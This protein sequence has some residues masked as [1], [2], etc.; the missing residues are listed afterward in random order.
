MN[1]YQ[2]TELANTLVQAKEHFD[3]NIT[4]PDQIDILEEYFGK[5]DSSGYYK[6]D[7]ALT[8]T[9]YSSLGN[10]LYSIVDPYTPRYEF[11]DLLE[12][13]GVEAY[14]FV[15]SEPNVSG[16]RWA[17]VES[18][19]YAS[20]E[21]P[22]RFGLMFNPEEIFYNGRRFDTRAEAEKWSTPN[23]R[24]VQLTVTQED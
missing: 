17:L 9:Y 22:I 14:W 10:D 19:S 5:L 6:R 15:V 21:P 7:T 24:V 18:N 8:F 4:S 3:V 16:E 23:T 20:Y 1:K 12:Y 2:L 13:V 11:G